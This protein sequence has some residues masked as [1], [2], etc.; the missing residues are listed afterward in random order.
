VVVDNDG[1]HGSRIATG[2][3]PLRQGFHR[4]KLK[5][6]QSEGGESLRINWGVSGDELKPL[7]GA[8]LYH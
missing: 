7:D 4:L 6:Y 8:P 2:H 1:N 5:Y 3:V